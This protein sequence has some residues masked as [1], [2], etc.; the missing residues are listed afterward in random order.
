MNNINNEVLLEQLQKYYIKNNIFSLVYQIKSDDKK[1][2]KFSKLTPYT[3]DLN[4]YINSLVISND[5]I[6]SKTQTVLTILKIIRNNKSL[7][8]GFLYGNINNN[9]ITNNFIILSLSFISKD[10]EYKHRLLDT[11]YINSLFN[12][13]I[14]NKVYKYISNNYIN[15]EFTLDFSIY[16]LENGKIQQDYKKI[17]SN[18]ILILKYY[19]IIW[20]VELH[21][22]YKNKKEINIQDDL[23]NILFSPSD[24]VIFQNLY[25]NYQ[26]EIDE[27]IPK[28]IYYNITNKLELGQKLLPF[29]YM[30]LKE[31]NHLLHFQWKEL[32]INRII[33]NL[34]HNNNSICFSLFIDWV[35]ITKSNKHLYNNEEIYKKINY[36]DKIQKVLQ[37]LNS[38]KHNFTELYSND[39]KSKLITK[40]EKKLQTLI[41]ETQ[42]N[43]IM[44]N[45]SLSF[46]SEYSGKHFFTI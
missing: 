28:I 23:A 7:N 11:N 38:A 40:L 5:F 30:Q 24:I 14:L 2:V 22:Q 9:T 41:N 46:L 26:S 45:V 42:T 25:K 15:K 13:I 18:N 36:S 27:L 8:F 37:L 44:S 39:I 19:S 20:I 32:L 29:N 12:N 43:I 35:F 21:I 4:K 16:N 33:N 3:L 31:Y 6:L 34:I 17:L 1:L 10:G